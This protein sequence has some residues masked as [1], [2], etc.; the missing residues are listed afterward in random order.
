MDRSLDV[1]SDYDVYTGLWIAR[2]RGVVQGA[3]ITLGRQSGAILIAFLALYVGLAG[4]GCW[5]I[6]RF[7]LHRIFSTSSDVDGVYH[8]RQTILRNAGTAHSAVW[9]LFQVSIAWRGK[10]AR[11]HIKRLLPV[12]GLSAVLSLAFAAA[13]MISALLRTQFGHV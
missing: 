5:N 4:S 6:V 3:T 10:G 1:S 11:R 2:A 8:Q 12:M 7:L 13:G 9:E